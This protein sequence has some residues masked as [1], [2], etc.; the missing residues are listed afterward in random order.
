[1]A[2]MGALPQRTPVG[3]CPGGL[4]RGWERVGLF[5]P[6][7]SS[8][9]PPLQH[10]AVEVLRGTMTRHN[11]VAYRDDRHGASQPITFEG[12]AW[13]DYVPL[14]LPWTLCIRDRVPPVPRPF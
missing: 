6:R 7:S 9:A 2:A 1:M 5:Q 3:N 11:L 13:R 12:D 14:R 4:Q 8:L 10:A